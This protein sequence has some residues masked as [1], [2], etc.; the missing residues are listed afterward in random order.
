MTNASTDAT[1]GQHTSHLTDCGEERA[2]SAVLAEKLTD[3]LDDKTGDERAEQA[4]S[5]AAE[6]VDKPPLAELATAARLLLLLRLFLL[7][8]RYWHVNCHCLRRF[9][10]GCHLLRRRVLDGFLRRNGLH[11]HF[12]THFQ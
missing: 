9:L 5:H 11:F 7:L 10:R 4:E 12:L 2:H 6:R 8:L 1:S 3:L